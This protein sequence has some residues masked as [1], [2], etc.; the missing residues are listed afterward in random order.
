[1]LDVYKLNLMQHFFKNSKLEIL[2]NI[3]PTFHRML[4]ERITHCN[5]KFLS[6]DR[7]DLA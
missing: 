7:I 3:C 4:D 1:M 6:G 5:C 2:S